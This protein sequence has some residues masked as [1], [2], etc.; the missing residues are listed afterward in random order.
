MEK[1]P[2]IIFRG[3]W[4]LNPDKNNTCR[5]L[6]LQ[7]QKNSISNFMSKGSFGATGVIR[8]YETEISND[9]SNEGQAI[10]S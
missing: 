6:K 2:Q 3:W 1:K 8:K 4:A 10:K 7:Y 9:N 5:T